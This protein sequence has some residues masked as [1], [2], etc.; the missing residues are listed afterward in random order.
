VGADART[1]LV[2]STPNAVFVLL[3]GVGEI[4]CPV[5]AVDLQR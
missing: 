1:Q 4:Y 3:D 2:V 5:I